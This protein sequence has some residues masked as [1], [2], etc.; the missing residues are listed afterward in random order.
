MQLRR[1]TA[2]STPAALSAVRMALGDEAIILS[3]RRQGDLIEIIATGHMD[4]AATLSNM[5]VDDIQEELRSTAQA[6]ATSINTSKKE[7]QRPKIASED[8]IETLVDA[9][10]EP[11]ENLEEPIRNTLSGNTQRL[12]DPDCGKK[13]SAK[14][15][16]EPIGNKLN[17]DVIGSASAGILMAA[18]ENQ[19]QKMEDHFR[20]LTVNL[21][22][23]VSSVESEHLKKLLSLG[24]GAELSVELVEQAAAGEPLDRALRLSYAKL[25]TLIPIAID[26]TSSVHGVTIVSGAPGSG[27]TTTLV[28]LAAEHVKNLGNQSIVLI[29]S[30]TRK[31]GAFEELESYG[32]IL[33][34]PT[35]HAHD[36][37]ELSSLIEAFK[38]KQLVLIDH[39]LPNDEDS[40][41]LPNCLLDSEDRDSV[42]HVFV[43][44]ATT[45]AH[46]ID[47]LISSHCTAD[48]ISCVVT[49]LDSSARLGEL[50]SVIIRHQ[51]PI[52]YCSNSASVQEPL[53][54]GDASELVTTAVAMA[55]RIRPSAD[56]ILLQRL[57]QPSNAIFSRNNPKVDFKNLEVL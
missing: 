13:A 32:R 33:G 40:V 4:D 6:L 5:S 18:F 56:D 10:K 39:T 14:A 50:L 3:N 46:T 52:S 31:I 29:C 9:L 54:K 45:Q 55:D 36:T 16:G 27:K 8:S 21:W 57:I 22:G 47:H 34:V 20:K 42:R 26:K 25:K 51:L 7:P 44:P 15:Q 48:N 1:F 24:I 11:Q 38:H 2:E 49:H 41:T 19:A 43:I 17:S 53:N 23:S 35:M 30:N 37:N 28:K 12:S